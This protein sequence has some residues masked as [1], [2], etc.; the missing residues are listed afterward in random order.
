MRVRTSMLRQVGVAV[1][2]VAPIALLGPGEASA[3]PVV[4]PALG[5]AT[6][7]S[8]TPRLG[9]CKST[10]TLC[11]LEVLAPAGGTEG[12]Y[13]KQVGGSA[14]ASKNPSYKF[15]PASSIKPVIALYALTRVMDGDL[16]LTT[17]VP[18]ISTAG[19]AEDCP[20]ATIVGTETLGT[21][22]QQ[23]LQVS[24]NNRTREL[25]QYF[26]VSALNAFITSLGMTS[27]HFQTSPLA[28]G[29]NVIGCN[30]YPGTGLPTTVDGNTISLSDLGIL[31]SKIAAMPAPY[32]AVF[33]TLAAGREM[34]NS[35]GY[36]YTG[37][38]PDVVSLVRSVAPTGLTSAQVNS[39]IDHSQLSV[40]GGSYDWHICQSGTACERAW[41]D[42]AFV[43][44][45][46]SCSGATLK[47]TEYVGSDFVSA[48][49]TAYASTPVAF[50]VTGPAITALLRVPVL[51]AIA[52]WKTCVPKQLPVLHVHGSTMRS[53]RT[54]G[55]GATL[56]TI[57]DDEPSDSSADMLGTISWGDGTSSVA[58][59][60][61]GKG[62]FTV[63]GWHPF[64]TGG[65]HNLV[66]TVKSE[67][68][69]VSTSG[70]T[71][72]EVG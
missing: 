49:D 44:Y 50:K 35:L 67:A 20:P 55:V 18:K 64:A 60:S 34:S 71:R 31:W 12:V 3:S 59:I 72:L 42:F 26:G 53:T 21:A 2:A 14:L 29:F 39:F 57:T 47:Q 22:L 16:N 52:S 65:V 40:K 25:M 7:R 46:P 70:S 5:T 15:E 69:G 4:R 13:L 17:S 37:I 41:A 1:A 54:V 33:Y 48:S 28:P 30:S 23:M 58:T 56:A 24:D 9:L 45:F 11:A 63:H 10:I 43:A 36:D 38:W 6:T 19:G 51:D 8:S 66:I 68:S 27:T 61:G 32:A 62:L